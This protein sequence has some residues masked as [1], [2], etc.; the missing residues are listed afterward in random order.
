[1]SISHIRQE[2]MQTIGKSMDELLLKYLKPIEKNW[3]PSDLLPDSK[4]HDVALYSVQSAKDLFGEDSQQVQST[5]DDD[6][7][8]C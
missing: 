6:S 4:Y 3:Q 5:L 8:T 1:M 2:V 7:T